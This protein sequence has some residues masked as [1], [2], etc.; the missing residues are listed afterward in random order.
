[1]AIRNGLN[2]KLVGITLF[3]MDPQF[4]FVGLSNTLIKFEPVW[5]RKDVKLRKEQVL[6][7]KIEGTRK[8][9]ATKA[10]I[11]EH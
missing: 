11:L 8:Q 2:K 10:I 7:I 3:L 5:R 4:I 9:T 1:M 6:T